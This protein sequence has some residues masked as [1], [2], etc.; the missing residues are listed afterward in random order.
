MRAFPLI[1]LLMLSA[2]AATAQPDPHGERKSYAKAYT[3]MVLGTTVPV[4]AGSAMADGEGSLATLGGIAIAGG[5]LVGPSA[6]RIYA[7]DRVLGTVLLRTAGSVAFTAGL[8]SALGGLCPDSTCGPSSE[9]L[10]AV[11]LLGGL[12]AYGGSLLV[13]AVL[14]HRAVRDYNERRAR[15][16]LAP[17]VDARSGAPLLGVRVDF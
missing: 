11:L 17:G 8:A 2:A 13:D 9:D 7:G 15:V 3:Y 14:T 10:G 4:L 16:T 5:L 6:G 12:T 1:A